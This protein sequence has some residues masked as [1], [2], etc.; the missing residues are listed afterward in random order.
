MPSLKQVWARRSKGAFG[1]DMLGAAVMSFVI[2]G[3]L[4]T[5]GLKIESQ[6][7][8]QTNATTEAEAFAAIGKTITATAGFSDW[9]SILQVV[10]AGALIIG[11]LYLAYSFSGKS[12][13]EGAGV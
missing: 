5:V 2:I 12:P 6:V 9:L 4:L 8:T 7:K 11:I 3:I 1:L 13:G 10:I